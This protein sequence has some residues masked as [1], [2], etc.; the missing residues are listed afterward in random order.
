[1]PNDFLLKTEIS[2][3]EKRKEEEMIQYVLIMSKTGL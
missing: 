2:L 3:C 1:M